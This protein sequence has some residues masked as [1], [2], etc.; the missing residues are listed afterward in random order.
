MRCDDALEWLESQ[1]SQGEWRVHRKPVGCWQDAAV[2]LVT[3]LICTRS[4]AYETESM[5][6]EFERIASI[7]QCSLS[8]KIFDKNS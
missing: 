7:T 4:A 2:I 3:R 6:D 5:I 8:S 1:S